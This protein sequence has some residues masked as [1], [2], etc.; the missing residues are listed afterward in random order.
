[1]VPKCVSHSLKHACNHCIVACS[2]MNGRWNI[3]LS[4]K[5]IYSWPIWTLVDLEIILLLMA[6]WFKT[7][8]NS[9]VPNINRILSNKNTPSASSLEDLTEYTYYLVKG[10]RRAFAAALLL[11]IILV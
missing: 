7:F 11:G 5:V 8:Y 3:E 10:K 2:L 1:M 4:S 9:F 6:C